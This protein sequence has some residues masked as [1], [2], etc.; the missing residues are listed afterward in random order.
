[1]RLAAKEHIQQAKQEIDQY[2]ATDKLKHGD[3]QK[4]VSCL[5]RLLCG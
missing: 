4:S 3:H 2:R 1:M 5:D